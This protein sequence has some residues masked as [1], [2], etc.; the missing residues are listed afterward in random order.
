MGSAAMSL[1]R[2]RKAEARHQS[3]SLTLRR[4][5][6]GLKRATGATNPERDASL[7]PKSPT[8]EMIAEGRTMLERMLLL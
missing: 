7:M 5:A 8:A 2:D 1:F 6:A 3:G 4:C